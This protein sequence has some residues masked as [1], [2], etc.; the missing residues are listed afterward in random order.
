MDRLF[1]YTELSGLH[2]GTTLISIGIESEYGKTFYAELNDYDKTQIDYL[3]QKNVID[4]LIMS[5]PPEGEEEYYAATRYF[6]NPIGDGNDLYKSYSLQLRCDK[7]ILKV[8]L[9]KWLS[10]FEQ[11]EMWGDCLAY[12]WVL[13]CEI[14]GGALNIPKN[15][16]YIP[17]DFSTLLKE[18]RVDPNINREIA[19]AN[20]FSENG[21]P[22]FFDKKG[23]LMQNLK[24]NSLW[25]AKLINS[26]YRKLI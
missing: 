8:E 17:F 26:C 25:N 1:F 7:A 20:A 15:I 11:V 14:F 16:Y 24:H 3:A 4:N 5:E 19:A 10:Q 21:E 18:K 6:D 13:F 12:D 2:Q 23:N 22:L 9:Q